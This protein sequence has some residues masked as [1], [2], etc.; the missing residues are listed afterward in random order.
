MN[1]FV[2]TNI[3]LDFFHFTSEDLEELRKLAVLVR[4]GEVKLYVPDQVIDEFKRNRESKIGDALK[5]CQGQ[6][7]SLQFPQLCKEYPEYETLREFQRDYQQTHE[8]LLEDIRQDVQNRELKADHAIEDLLANATRITTDDGILNRARIRV[9]KGNPP[10]KKGSLGDAVNWEAVLSAVPNGEDMTIVT[11][12]SDYRSPLDSETLDGFLRDEWENAH[13]GV[14]SFYRNLSSLFRERFPDIKLAAELEKELL[15]RSLG[16]S[17]S[18]DQ[19]HRIVGKLSKV[20]EFTP[21]QREDIAEAAVS[22]S[23]IR[24]IIGDSD[25]RDFVAQVIEGHEDEIEESVLR[26]VK[27]LLEEDEEEWEDDEFEDFPF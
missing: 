15:I 16:T 20:G 23:Q 24:W 25:V 5:R 22:N 18:F 8:R 6:R 10:G 3:L 4:E 9:E 27:G 2:D 12:D 13:G 7:L 11:D 17:G 26:H 1:L 14:V 21:A 19:T